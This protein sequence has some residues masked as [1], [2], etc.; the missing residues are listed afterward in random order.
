MSVDDPRAPTL[1]ET[2]WNEKSSSPTRALTFLYIELAWIN[3]F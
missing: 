2:T 3:F 1:V